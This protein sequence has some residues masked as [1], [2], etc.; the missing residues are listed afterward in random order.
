MTPKSFTTARPCCC[1]S[2]LL[3]HFF[4]VDFTGAHSVGLRRW[5]PRVSQPAGPAAERSCPGS[6]GLLHQLF[7]RRY[8]APASRTREQWHQLLLGLSLWV[9]QQDKVVPS[10]YRTTVCS[11]PLSTVAPLPQSGLERRVALGKWEIQRKRWRENGLQR[12]WMGVG[13]SLCWG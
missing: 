1:Q 10:M 11:W 13:G 5:H 7:A 2:C 8:E 4:L 12:V 9:Y 3:H 6:H